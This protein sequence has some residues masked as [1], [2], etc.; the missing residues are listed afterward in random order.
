MKTYIADITLCVN[1]EA[2]LDDVDEALHEW[3]DRLCRWNPETEIRSFKVEEYKHGFRV[4]VD[5]EWC[6]P[7]DEFAETVRSIE[8]ALS[9]ARNKK[10]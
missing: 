9:G 4:M 1:T 5:G 7:S 8:E 2:S 10:E 6:E 3:L